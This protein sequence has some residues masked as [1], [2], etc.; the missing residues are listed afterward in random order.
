MS[1]LQTAVD[2]ESAGM[3][4]DV[5]LTREFEKAMEQAGL[6]RSAMKRLI[7]G[8]Q[9]TVNGQRS[10]ASAR[11]KL[12]DIVRIERLPATEVA[13]APEALPLDVLYEDNDCIVINKAAGVIVHPAAGASSGTLV[14]ALLHHCPDLEGIGGERRPG[15]VHRLDKETSGAM[16]V[17]KNGFAF[18]QLARQFKER[19]VTKE[20]VALV[21]G[22]LRGDKGVID[23][24]IGR[25]RADRKRMSSIHSLRRTREAIT[26]WQVERCFE[27]KKGSGPSLCVSLLRLRPRTGRMHQIRVHLADLGHPLLG[28]KVY[29]RKRRIAHGANGTM[30][31]LQNFARHALHAEKLGL[32]HPRSGVP[33]YF[34]A[35]LAEDMVGLLKLLREESADREALPDR[36]ATG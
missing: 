21:W 3:R 14:N 18:Q 20:Y 5:F 31:L 19:R 1:A 23:R 4:L 16:I 9:V 28:D 33:M 36:E 11:V 10:K 34:H 35:P 24:P 25:H 32:T 6:S 22:K 15:I 29:G 30:G 26:A 8:G 27:V 17:A 12:N 2:A 7:I 13:L